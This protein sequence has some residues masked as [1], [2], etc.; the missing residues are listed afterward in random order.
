MRIFDQPLSGSDL[1]GLGEIVKC[2]YLLVI[3]V[4]ADVYEFCH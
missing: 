2:C 3:V 1:L 4:I